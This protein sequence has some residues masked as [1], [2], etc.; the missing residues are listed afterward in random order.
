V[1]LQLE[2]FIGLGEPVLGRC[3]PP[4]ATNT[5]GPASHLYC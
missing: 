4:H 1:D 5:D 2:R 3:V